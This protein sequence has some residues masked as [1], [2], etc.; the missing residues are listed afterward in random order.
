M[1]CDGSCAESIHETMQEVAAI[2]AA[3][4]RRIGGPVELSAAE[5]EALGLDEGVMLIRGETGGSLRVEVQKM[6]EG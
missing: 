6:G 5:L 1:S 4:V 3:L 2:I